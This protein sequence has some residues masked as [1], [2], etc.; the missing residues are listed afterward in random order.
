VN[1]VEC[2]GAKVAG[3]HGPGRE[4]A[5]HSLFDQG[6]VRPSRRIAALNKGGKV[7]IRIPNPAQGARDST[8]HSRQ[9]ADGFQLRESFFV[10]RILDGRFQELRVHWLEETSSQ[11]RGELRQGQ[12]L[13]PAFA[14]ARRREPPHLKCE[15]P[16]NNNGA[17][18]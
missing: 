8:R 16:F 14:G 18:A 15:R 5:P 13:Y 4:L 11:T 1:L 7:Y 2:S 10:E 6:E 9:L 3:Q 17:A 12:Y